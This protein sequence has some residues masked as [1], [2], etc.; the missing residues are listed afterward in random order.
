[1]QHGWTMS[2]VRE[3]GLY[4][5]ATCLSMEVGQLSDIG[6]EKGTAVERSM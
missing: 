5:S 3:Q 1:M 4:F 2:T 6:F